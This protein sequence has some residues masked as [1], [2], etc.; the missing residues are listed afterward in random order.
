MSAGE[1]SVAALE[2]NRAAGVVS[3]VDLFD[4]A[5]AH[6]IMF[7]LL[8][9]SVPYL[10]CIIAGRYFR[11]STDSHPNVPLVVLFASFSGAIVG[12]MSGISREPVIAA[13]LTGMFGLVGVIAA[14]V[15]K[16][17]PSSR[18]VVASGAAAFLF[19]LFLANS[20]S[21]INR[22]EI[23][24]FE[25]C[26]DM[27]VNPDVDDRIMERIAG[28]CREVNAMPSVDEEVVILDGPPTDG[29]LAPD[30]NAGEEGTVLFLEGPPTDDVQPGPPTEAPASVR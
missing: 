22:T 30:R 12:L 4:P 5:V 19:S 20:G 13:I 14:M 26:M 8:V 16:T 27:L 10:I 24:M 17:G 3:P 2:S 28:L 6:A 1:K 18:G 9:T 25:R 29:S 11:V 23:E 15:P 21:T 7:V